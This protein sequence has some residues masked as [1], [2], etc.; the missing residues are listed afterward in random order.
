MHNYVHTGQG[1]PTFTNVNCSDVDELTHPEEYD[2]CLGVE[3]KKHNLFVARDTIALKN[4]GGSTT[5]FN[6][7]LLKEMTNV[8]VSFEDTSTLAG[9]EVHNCLSST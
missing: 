9:I 4:N 8:A 1:V 5:S 2:R 3:Y 6:G 7:H